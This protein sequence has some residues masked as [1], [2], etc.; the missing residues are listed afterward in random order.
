MNLRNSFLFLD[1]VGERTERQLWQSG[2]THWDEFHRSK[3]PAIHHSSI[4]ELSI[5]LA[6]AV[7]AIETGDSTFFHDRL[8]S[9]SRWRLYEDFCSEA[10][11]LDIETT[12]LDKHRNYITT[13]SI[14]REGEV[15]TYI[16]GINF[17]PD[18][19]QYVLHNAPLLVTFNGARFDVPFL[20]TALEMPIDTPHLDLLYPCKRVGLTGGLK[21]IESELKVARDTD[22]DGRE[23][24]QLW[25]QYQA[26]DDDALDRLVHYNQLDTINLERVADTVMDRLDR[27]IFEPYRLPV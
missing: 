11:F 24:V 27:E 19:V 22:I 20:E 16:R 18:E 17:E 14:Y 4:D 6:D 21:R 25:N 26:G 5:Q 7:D 9:R 1:G 10:C 23:A 3:L 12:G 15:K 8:P 2:I 13:V